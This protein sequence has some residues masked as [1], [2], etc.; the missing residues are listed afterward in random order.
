MKKTPS[1]LIQKWAE[2]MNRHFSKEDTQMPRKGTQRQLII[3]EMHIKITV[4]YHLTPV[5]M[6]IIKKKS[7]GKNA[8]K[9]EPSC[10]VGGNASWYN[11]YGIQYGGFSKIKNRAT[12]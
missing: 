11:H 4:R 5:R 10:T 1:Y 7:I 6:S 8:E 12:I 9:R 2:R 3:K